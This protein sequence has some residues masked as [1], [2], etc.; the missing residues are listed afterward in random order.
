MLPPDYMPVGR[1]NENDFDDIVVRAGGSRLVRDHARETRPNADYAIGGAIVELKLVE[2]EGFDKTERQRKLAK[3]F[4]EG[5]SDR[6]T[7]VLDPDRLSSDQQRRYYNIMSTPLKTHVKKAATQLEAT[8][9][10]TGGQ[11]SRVLLLV[12]NGYSALNADDFA[13]IALKCVRNDTTK[14]DALITAGTYYYSDKFDMFMSF[15]FDLH[16]VNVDRPFTS[17]AALRRAWNA[18]AEGFMIALI[19]PDDQRVRDRLPV[20]DLSFE[21]EGVRLVKP[22]RKIG[23]DPSLWQKQRPRENSLGTERCPPAAVTFPQLTRAD[24]EQCKSAMPSERFFRDTFE[25]WLQFSQAEEQRHE[26]EAKNP[27]QPFVRVRTAFSEFDAWCERES[28]ARSARAL[29]QFSAEVFTSAAKTLVGQARE[30][31]ATSIVPPAYVLVRTEEIG[32]DVA[33]DMGQVLLVREKGAGDPQVTEVASN[34]RAFFPYSLRIG[35]AYAVKHGLA[36]LMY[37]RDR[38]YAWE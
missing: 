25:A 20:V 15:P 9:K 31:T 21:I 36:H 16:P 5:Q 22:T 38:T 17:F 1:L 34:L 7:I 35:A 30:R 10:R 28:R 23:H 2:E 4:R 14:I 27:H 37:I 11:P 32:Q 24:W 29:C 8:A 18:F 26:R 33:N 3:L 12:N 19:Q 13:R 6:P